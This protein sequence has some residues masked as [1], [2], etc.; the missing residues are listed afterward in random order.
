MADRYKCFLCG[1]II[2]DAEAVAFVQA[3]I[4]A[5][6]KPDKQGRICGHNIG[7]HKEA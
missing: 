4:P 2:T 3:H 7:A 5:C 6:T 1:C